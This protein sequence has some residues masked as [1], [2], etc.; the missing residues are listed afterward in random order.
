MLQSWSKIKRKTIVVNILKLYEA[1]Q[2]Y[3][4]H[5]KVKIYQL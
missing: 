3:K 5:I 4:L 2:N 1:I